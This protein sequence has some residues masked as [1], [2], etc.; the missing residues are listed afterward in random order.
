MTDHRIDQGGD[1]LT[2]F[3][4]MDG[5]SGVWTRGRQVLARD[6]ISFTSINSRQEEIQSTLG[7]F[8]DGSDLVNDRLR[9]IDLV[10]VNSIFHRTQSGQLETYK[11]RLPAFLLYHKE[12]FDVEIRHIHLARLLYAGLEAQ[13]AEHGVPTLWFHL[14]KNILFAAF[15]TGTGE[16]SITSFKV[17]KA[18]DVYYYI[19]F[20]YQTL[21]TTLPTLDQ[22]VI[23]G[24]I[25]NMDKIHNFF[26]ENIPDL[27]LA[28]Y[29]Q[30]SGI[31][32]KPQVVLNSYL[33]EVK[34]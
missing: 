30:W 22:I 9:A 21:Q 15:C 5:L 14:R 13:F 16:I 23:S 34:I 26:E 8:Y 12:Y 11:N 17:Q 29:W 32:G 19:L 6:E 28:T 33:P 20:N 10:F 25:V 31:P 1:L 18:L 3:I 2:L 24:E 27:E 7:R 4:Y